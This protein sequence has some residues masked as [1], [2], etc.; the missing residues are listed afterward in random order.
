MIAKKAAQFESTITLTNLENAKTAD[1]KKLFAL[2]NL[3]VKYDNKIRITCDGDDSQ[4]AM[5]AMKQC[6]E[7]CL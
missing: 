3:M 6:I 1:A 7:E 2:M 5:A 4:E